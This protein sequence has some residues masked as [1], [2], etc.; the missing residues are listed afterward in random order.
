MTPVRR[1]YPP[2][3]STRAHCSSVKPLLCRKTLRRQALWRSLPRQGSGRSGKST[4]QTL[5]FR[6]VM[7]ISGVKPCDGPA[8]GHRSFVLNCARQDSNLG[9]TDYESAALTPELRALWARK[10]QALVARRRRSPGIGSTPVFETT[11]NGSIVG[12]SGYPPEGRWERVWRM[13]RASKIPRWKD[14]GRRRPGPQQETSFGMRCGNYRGMKIAGARSKI[15]N[16]AV[17]SSMPSPG[18]PKTSPTPAPNE[19]NPPDNPKGGRSI[20]FGAFAR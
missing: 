4:P 5:G 20:W 3:R 15:H 6:L 10:L 19:P 8:A 11:P 2:R 18:R 16:S 13:A 9:R 7:P 12:C 17:A 1:T 14:R